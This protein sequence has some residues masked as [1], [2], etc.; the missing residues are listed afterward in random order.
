MARLSNLFVTCFLSF[1][2]IFFV[3]YISRSQDLNLRVLTIHSRPFTSE[4]ASLALLI[5]FL[6]YHLNSF[7]SFPLQF[8][9]LPYYFQYFVLYEETYKIHMFLSETGYVF[10][11][12]HGW[13]Q[14]VSKSLEHNKVHQQFWFLRFNLIYEY[15][16]LY[17]RGVKEEEKERI[18]P[19]ILL[20]KI[21]MVNPNSRIWSG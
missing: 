5:R 16:L 10:C 1:Y 3:W 12:I 17:V 15:N 9:H 18:W 20:I 6:S 14:W 21:Y 4:Q 11:P 8:S 13:V 7:I 2:I 19:Q